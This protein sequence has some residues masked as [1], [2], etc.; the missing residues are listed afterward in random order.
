MDLL[1]THLYCTL[2]LSVSHSHFHFHLLIF[3]LSLSLLLFLYIY[4]QPYE[5]W[6]NLE[7]RA[8]YE[9][10]KE[11]RCDFLWKAVERSI[12]D[13]RQ[14][15]KVQLTASPLTH[16]RFNRR[17]RG[18]Y[19]PALR[20]GQAKFPYPRTEIPGLFVCGDSVFPGIGV[21]AVAASGALHRFCL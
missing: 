18:S 15:A 2:T 19:G 13:V 14:R 5:L 12:P 7:S 9:A 8:D 16:E 1:N 17:S 6:E 11:Q 10:L 20:A 4:L 3:S 21:P